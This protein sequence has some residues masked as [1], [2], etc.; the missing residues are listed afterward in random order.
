M[1]RKKLIWYPGAIYHITSRGNHRNDIFRDEEDYLVYLTILREALERYNGNLYCYCLM[2]NHVHLVIE[3]SD[4][5]VSEIMRRINLFYTKYFNNKYNLI[6]HLFQGRYFAELVEEDKYILE[7]SRYVHL[8][9]IKANMVKKP[10]EYQ[11]SSYAMYIGKEKEKLI[12]SEKILSYF[13][14]ENSR[15]LYKKFLE[16]AIKIK[17]CED[18][19]I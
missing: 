15:E 5:K 3:T 11:W 16:S 6:G 7:V 19:V 9:P 8:N 12:S 17:L 1:V 14:K 4:I 18:E 2:T 10:E 13:R